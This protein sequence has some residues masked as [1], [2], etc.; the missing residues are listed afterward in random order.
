M[1]LTPL[2]KII[3]I[4]LVLGAAVGGYRYWKQ[5]KGSIL[6]ASGGTGMNGNAGLGASDGGI[7]PAS[8]SNNDS[9]ND[10]NRNS[11]GNQGGDK[12]QARDS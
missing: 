3:L 12:H 8:D 2:S 1:K 6:T 11:N 4:L 9:N 7:P 5:S 10:P